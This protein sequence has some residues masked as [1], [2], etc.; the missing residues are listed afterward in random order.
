MRIN[1]INGNISFQSAIRV[2]LNYLEHGFSTRKEQVAYKDFFQ[3]IRSGNS[4]KYGKETANNVQNFLTKHGIA[5]NP[6]KGGIRSYV[7]K[8]NYYL[9][10]DEDAIKA[11]DIF[12]KS[13]KDQA[14]LDL[15]YLTGP[16]DDMPCWEKAELKSKNLHK[17]YREN[18]K[19]GME[20]NIAELAQSDKNFESCRIN[21]ITNNSEIKAIQFYDEQKTDKL[22]LQ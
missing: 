9:F 22:C 10:T 11:K 15:K 16:T 19:L 1:K 8:G 18:I 14:E 5:F 7:A 17:I 3:M 12:I 13:K 2:D 20:G 21:I 6:K 4:E